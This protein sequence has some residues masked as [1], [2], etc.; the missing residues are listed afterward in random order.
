MVKC[1]TPPQENLVVS[2][3]NMEY[4]S[5]CYL[6]DYQV[7]RCRAGGQMKAGGSTIT[8]ATVQSYGEF[9]YARLG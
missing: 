8:G 7:I 4:T 3:S 2:W 9:A 5:L 1:P 6:G